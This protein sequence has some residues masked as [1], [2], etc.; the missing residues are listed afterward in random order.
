ML[1][2]TADLVRDRLSVENW[3]ILNGL[4]EDMQIAIDRGFD[5]LS[6]LLGMLGQAIT[7]LAAFSGMAAESMTRS[8][9]WRFMDLGRRLERSMHTITLVQEFLAC[10]AGQVPSLQETLL[11]VGESLMTYRSRYLANL[12]LDLVLD[13]L[14]TDET[15]PRAVAFQLAAIEEHVSQLPHDRSEALLSP[16][17]RLAIN[18]CN[19][20]RQVD[21]ETLGRIASWR[22][23]PSAGSSLGAAGGATAA[24]LGIG[25][26]QVFR[27]CQ[28]PAPTGRMVT[29]S[30]A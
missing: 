22:R 21:I 13:L 17:R 4:R 10:G 6:D 24:S 14:L 20:I 30:T 9:G 25:V 18:M 7:G 2:Q 16:D 27:P 28:R 26:A 19:R 11:E 12:R 8:Q 1:A 15:N 5:T 3:K 29:G 23:S